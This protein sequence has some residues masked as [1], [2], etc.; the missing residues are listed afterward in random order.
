MKQEE[1]IYF[2]LDLRTWSLLNFESLA[3]SMSAGEL[4][5]MVLTNSVANFL[6][7][8]WL[9]NVP[10]FFFQGTGLIFQVVVPDMVIFYQI[11]LHVCSHC[12]CKLNGQ[13]EL[14]SGSNIC[15]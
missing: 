5:L 2:T 3:F 14:N 4:P 13:T 7:G 6:Q 1:W 10:L 12:S 9:R 11:C 15:F 8:N